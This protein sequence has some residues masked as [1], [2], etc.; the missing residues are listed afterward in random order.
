M[1]E[2]EG[3]RGEEEEGWCGGVQGGKTRERGARERIT[4]GGRR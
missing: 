2:G 4:Q 1:V 3:R